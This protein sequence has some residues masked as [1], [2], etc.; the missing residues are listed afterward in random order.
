MSREDKKGK[1]E[2]AKKVLRIVLAVVTVFAGTLGVFVYRGIFWMF[3]TLLAS[4]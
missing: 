1:N 3:K 2:M 4:G